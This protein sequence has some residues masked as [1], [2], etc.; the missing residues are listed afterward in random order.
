MGLKGFD[1][2]LAKARK[3]KGFTQEEL[4]LRLGVTPQAVS[5]WE[6][7]AGYPDLELLYH[8]SEV[9]ECATDYLLQRD[10]HRERLTESNDEQQRK[11]LLQ[12][13]LAEPLVLEAGTGLVELLMEEHKNQFPCIQVLRE[14]MASRYG[15]LLPVLRIRDNE[16]IGALEYRITSYGQVLDSETVDNVALITFQDMCEHLEKVTLEHFSKIINRQMV[17]TLVDNVADNYPAVVQGVI[18][19]KVSLSLLQ[20]ILSGL[21]EKQIPIRNLVKIIEIL[22]EEVASTRNVEQLI[23]I[24]KNNL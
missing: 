9:L 18:P 15:I 16:E 10:I 8:I 24:I 1:D 19:E 3:E 23:E 17:K 7:G 13:L 20:K 11:Q 12:K 5:K 2:R 21:V 22:E 4:A 6:R 14:R